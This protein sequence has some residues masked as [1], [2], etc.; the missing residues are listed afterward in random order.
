MTGEE[1]RQMIQARGTD[2][3]RRERLWVREA[4][5]MYPVFQMPVE[6][7]LLNV[8][9]R[10]FA[11]ER[12]LLEEQ[13]GH[14]LDPENNPNDERIVETILLD[15]NLEV[16]GDRLTGKPGKDYEALKGDWQRRHQETALWIRPDGLVRN[17]NRRL[18]ML[19]RLQREEGLEGFEYV[20]AVVLDPADIDEVALF[21]MEQREQLTE[22]LK[23]RYT[24]INLLLAIRDA[25][26]ARGIDW[27]DPDDLERVAGELQYVVGNNQQ[28]A[29]VQLNA[30]KYMDAYLEDSG[31][32]GQYHKLIGQI[33]RFR[34]VGRA[35]ARIEAEYPDDSA[36]ML[37]LL[38]AAIRAGMPHTTI[39]DLRRM[40]REDREKHTELVTAVDA[41]EQQWEVA[42]NEAKLLDPEVIH[43]VDA[44][45]EGDTDEEEV[46]APGPNVPN[47]PQAAIVNVVDNAID[48]FEASRSDDVLKILSQI[49]N[50][51]DALTREQLANSLR[52][53]EREAVRVALQTL[54][55]WVDE[56]RD[57]LVDP[58][59]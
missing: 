59:S 21:D 29:L 17:G 37:R 31:Q 46:E 9:N 10:R 41:L 44:T 34:D 39:R 11:A 25:A 4:W 27:Y 56:H 19:K 45:D 49:R 38:F 8:E 2:T 16:D 20:D 24:D 15:T 40:F 54:F 33:E 43:P 12:A 53:D 5:R 58:P 22:N 42:G 6:A 13:L 32:P 51:L 28:Y 18:A 52:G 57:L 7:L 50:R 35:M 23:V 36:A 3:D 30:I 47:Y 14:D 55:D 26:V 48:A 1:R